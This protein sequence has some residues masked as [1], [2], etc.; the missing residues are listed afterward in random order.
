[1]PFSFEAVDLFEPFE[2]FDLADYLECGL[3]LG[4][5]YPL[6]MFIKP[7]SSCWED[8][9]SLLAKDSAIPLTLGFC[10]LGSVNSKSA[11][12]LLA[13]FG[14]VSSLLVGGSFVF[15]FLFS[16][17]KSPWLNGERVRKWE[18]SLI[19]AG[20][21][22]SWQLSRPLSCSYVLGAGD[23]RDEMM[24]EG[25][26]VAMLEFCYVYW[27][28]YRIWT[29]AAGIMLSCSFSIWFVRYYYSGPFIR[30]GSCWMSESASIV[31]ELNSEISWS[32]R[33]ESSVSRAWSNV[34]FAKW[35]ISGF[36]WNSE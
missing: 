27:Y 18:E 3:G 34:P 15:G 36:S 22:G 16:K 8:L 17:L 5:S 12:Y 2:P 14:S 1:M 19:I 9:R 26:A 31:R 6:M 23:S 33:L 35:V 30:E 29:W 32:I 10:M 4:R 13:S 20:L 25:P 7:F 28:D 21:A 24:V 11:L